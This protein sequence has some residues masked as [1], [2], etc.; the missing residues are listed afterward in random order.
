MQM[1]NM[2]LQ[3]KKGA[4]CHQRKLLLTFAGVGQQDQSTVQLVVVFTDPAQTGSSE[5]EAPGRYWC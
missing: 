2:T 1:E 4:Q 3:I 5:S